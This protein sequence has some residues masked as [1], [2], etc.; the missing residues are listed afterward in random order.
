MSDFYNQFGGINPNPVPK[1]Q[2][3][4]NNLLEFAKTVQNPEQQ[5]KDLLASGQMTQEQFQQCAQ[6]ANL[7]TNNR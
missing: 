6:I 4:A 3:K 5:V 7:L 2:N 1:P